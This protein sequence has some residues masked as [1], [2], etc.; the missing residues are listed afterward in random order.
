[1]DTVTKG[2][3]T[4]LEF[5]ASMF[6]LSVRDG[7]QSE[8]R[9]NAALEGGGGGG[10]GGGG[11]CSSGRALSIDAAQ[12]ARIL[13]AT[14]PSSGVSFETTADVCAM[15]QSIQTQQQHRHASD[16]ATVS[17]GEEGRER[18]FPHNEDTRTTTSCSAAPRIPSSNL[19]RESADDVL[20]SFGSRL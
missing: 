17:R 16:A 8:L 2:F 13:H 4:L 19:A 7:L 1:M 9:F 14:L 5:F 18:D 12:E 11:G 20:H 3:H 15:Q 6:V 10:S